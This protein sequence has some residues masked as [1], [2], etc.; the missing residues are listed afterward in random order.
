MNPIR[1]VTPI[2][3]A[4]AVIA[5]ALVGCA[6]DDKDGDSITGPVVVRADCTG[7]HSDRASIEATAAPVEI[8]EEDPGEG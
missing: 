2:S 4:A 6:T 5:I 8:V 7:C 1:L 3:L